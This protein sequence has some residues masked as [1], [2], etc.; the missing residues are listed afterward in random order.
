LH[1]EGRER[2]ESED[3]EQGESRAG[4]WRVLVWGSAEEVTGAI[5]VLSEE[6]RGNA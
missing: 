3:G 5:V 6:R 4:A 2:E 1:G